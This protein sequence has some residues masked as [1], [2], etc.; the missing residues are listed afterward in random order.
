MLPDWWSLKVLQPLA[1]G[2]DVE[3]KLQSDRHLLA[4]N[5]CLHEQKPS[6]GGPDGI[7]TFS[8][9]CSPPAQ[10]DTHRDGGPVGGLLPAAGWRLTVVYLPSWQRDG[11]VS[12]WALRIFSMTASSSAVSS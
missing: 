8:V 12:W 2:V 3:Q 7:R 1:S 10:A 9:T 11:K 6:E 4:G 5:R